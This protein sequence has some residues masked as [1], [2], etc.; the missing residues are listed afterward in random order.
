[1]YLLQWDWLKFIPCLP[2]VACSDSNRY[3]SSFIV[4]IEDFTAEEFVAS[5]IRVK[6]TNELV[7]ALAVTS[8]W[9]RLLRN[10][11]YVRSQ[12]FFAVTM[13]NV[14]FWD[15]TPCG[16]SKNRRLE[17]RNSSVI[18]VTQISELG[19]TSVVTSKCNFPLMLVTAN[20]VPSSPI[21]VTLMREVVCFS[22]KS[23]IKR[24]TRHHMSE[25]E[26]FILIY[27]SYWM[28]IVSMF[29]ACCNIVFDILYRDGSDLK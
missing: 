20:V 4:R 24:T 23:V 17:Q 9:S 22:E 2:Q 27:C 5:I 21:L 18:R 6:R 25:N 8:N 28:F 29:M 13:K 26:I 15:F 14:I 7:R 1:V 11:D 3:T 19:T 10:A 12:V 16:S